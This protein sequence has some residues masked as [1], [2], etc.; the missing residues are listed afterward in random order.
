MNEVYLD[1][2]HKC[3]K[4]VTG[5]EKGIISDMTELTR[6]QVEKMTH[7]EVKEEIKKRIWVL[8]L[9]QAKA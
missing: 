9:N 3:F 7:E 8:I 4:Y 1:T 6:E 5:E 2:Q